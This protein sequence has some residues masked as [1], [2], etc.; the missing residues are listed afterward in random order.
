[1][2]HSK[3]EKEGIIERAVLKQLNVDD[4]EEFKNHLKECDDCRNELLRTKLLFS[5][6]GSS[7]RDKGNGKLTL[8]F[9]IAIMAAMLRY[10]QKYAVAISIVAI[11]I[12]STVVLESQYHFLSSIGR[13]K[14]IIANNDA[15]IPNSYLESIIN[16]SLRSGNEVNVSSPENDSQFHYDGKNGFPFTM[17]ARIE[18]AK[19]K[20]VLLKIFSNS[21]TDYL[22]DSSVYMQNAELAQDAGNTILSLEEQLFLDKGLYYL[23]LQYKNE[24]DYIYVARFYVK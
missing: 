5:V 7:S 3:I 2:D 22:N 14:T 9:F 11:V 13:E 16:T 20:D 6:A 23:T 12:I 1:M 8:P 4:L 10:T 17:D 15:F 21:E 19:D 18:H 24:I